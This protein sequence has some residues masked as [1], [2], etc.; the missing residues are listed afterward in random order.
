[1]FDWLAQVV[2]DILRWFE[3]TTQPGTES[4]SSPGRQPLQLEAHMTRL[5]LTTAALVGFAYAANA[6]TCITGVYG[7]VGCPGSPGY[8]Q[9]PSYPTPHRAIEGYSVGVGSLESFKRQDLLVE[10][11]RRLEMEN[12]ILRRQLEADRRK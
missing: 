6:Q 11:T 7:H 4:G 9:A 8:V 5:L 3:S 12:E 1:M 10:Q 2:G